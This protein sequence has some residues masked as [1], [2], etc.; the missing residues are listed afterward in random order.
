[1]AALSWA[2]LPDD[3]LAAIARL[4]HG[5]ELLKLSQVNGRCWRAFS[6]AELYA[7]RLSQVCYQRHRAELTE[8]DDSFAAARIGS[9]RDYALASSLRFAGQ[10]RD[11]ELHRTLLPRSFAPV[12]SPTDT[13]FGLYAREDDEIGESPRFTLDSWF[14]LSPPEGGVYQGGVL[15]GL[16]NEK[17]RQDG[18]QWPHF[19]CQVLHVD[20]SGN[21]YCS[22]TSEKLRV[23]AQL[24]PSR[25]YHVALIVEGRSQR[26]FLDGELVVEQDDQELQLESQPFYYAQ[27]GAGCISGDS[28][29]KPA[30]SHSGWYVFHGVIDDLRVWHEALPAQQ[31]YSL[32]RDCAT[33]PRRPAF[34]LKRGVPVWMAH[35]VEKVQ[36]T[37]PREHRCQVVAACKR[38]E[39]L[40]SWV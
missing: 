13:L 35:G 17:C 1:M 28:V 38:G 10:P 5:F 18:C 3:V 31:I 30:D 4:L 27:V 32:S 21:L 6:R 20:P 26:V 39:D 25:W 34:S 7:A 8:T 29:G 24:E 37:R 23:S 36:C 22:V 14:S 40:G 33:L 9:K 19:H 2:A 15:L 12:Y 11:S 16:Q